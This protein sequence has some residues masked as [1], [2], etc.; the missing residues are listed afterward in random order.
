METLFSTRKWWD[1]SSTTYG[2]YTIQ[3]EHKRSG[4]DM[5]YRFKWKFWLTPSGAYFYNA[6]KMPIYLNG[7]NV[8]TIQIK[9]YKDTEKGWTYEG[10][11]GWYT[12]SNKTS[13]TIPVYFKVVDTGGYAQAGWTVY[14]TSST[15]NL[16]VDPAESVLGS[17]S[18]FTIGNA[19]TIP[20]T[21]YASDLS[22]TLVVKYGS[23]T[24]K[25][26]AGITN[27]YSLSFSTSELNTI[28]SLMST[29][30]SGTFSFDLTTYSGSTSVG[31][32]SKS[33]KGSI[34]NANPT[35]SSSNITYKD[36]NSTTVNVT[37]NNQQLVQGLS[38]LLVTLT[39][40]TG[41]KGASITKYEATINGVTKTLTSAGNID[42]GVINSS[43]DLTLSVK[44]TDSR[45]NTTSA[46]KTITFLA[47]TLPTAI[48]SLKRKN[49]YEDETYL[50]VDASC[51]SVN[52]KN[53]VSIQYQYKKSSDTNYSSL[54]TIGDNTQITLVNDKESAWNYKIILTD[55]FGTT[56]YNV[57]LPRGKFILFVDTKKLSVGV[58]CFPTNSESLEVNGEKIGAIDFSKIYPIG[59]IYMSVN[60][61]NPKDLFGG[62]WEQLK[63]RF[64]LAAGSS[65]SAGSTGGASTVALES[66]HLPGHTHSFSATSGSTT[67]SHTHSFS[68]TSGAVS[69]GHTHS[70][71]SHTHSTPSHTHSFSANFYIR[72]GE[73]SGTATLAGGT[74]TSVTTGAYSSSWGNGFKTSS[75]SHKPDRLNISGTTGSSSGTTGA[76][77]GSTGYQSNSHTH[78]VSGTTGS[79]GA[80]HT[81]SVSGTTGSTGSGS[82]HNNMPPYL[83]VYVWKRTG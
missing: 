63:D 49:N 58:N 61:T 53:S 18:D 8:A 51:S 42:Y 32:S 25:T 52:S 17:I 4:A 22:D 45:G 6:I 50:K 33:A 44:V 41:N 47:W 43:K 69:T 72:H 55:K 59:S 36:N 20:I 28:Y 9:T 46:S 27:N 77:S 57:T 64:L 79:G 19:I 11:T 78:S 70:L 82:A 40:A 1:Y 39:S 31:S 56:T 66:G 24:I 21:K 12:V 73:N 14:D 68:A 34:T 16:V 76:S 48:I 74:N 35:F 67:A 37:G 80:A 38:S 15:Y 65:Y 62:T 26:I 75:Y 29:V 7:T 81:H 5:Q 71:N 30:N 60:S 83:A 13:G 2:A 54:V 10:T 3:Y 23:T